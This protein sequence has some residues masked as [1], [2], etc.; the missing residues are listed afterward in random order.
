MTSDLK[1]MEMKIYRRPERQSWP[2]LAGRQKTAVPE[3]V[4]STVSRIL[5]DVRKGGDSK[6]REYVRALDGYDAGKGDLSVT[7]REMEEATAIVSE[8]LKSAIR[9]AAANIRAFHAAQHCRDIELE[10][11]PGVV[12]R[13]KNVPVGNVGLYIPGGTAPLFSTVLMLAVPAS[14]AGCGRTA[15]FTPP[16]PDGKVSPAILYCASLCGVSEVYRIGGAV[17]VAVMAYGTETIRKVDKIF[18]PGN[19]YVTEAKRQVS[20]DCA[21]DMPAGPSEVM[22]LAD[23]S[24]RAEYVA[25]DFLS[26]LEHGRDSQAILVSTS[27]QLVQEVSEALAGQL[28]SLSRKEII[29]ASIRRSMA[30]IFDTEEEMVEFSNFYAPEH[31]IIATCDY[32]KT[33]EGIVNAGSVFLG[34]WS[35]ES[36]G[37]YASGTNHT[38]PTGGWAVSCSGVSL[39]SFMKKITF[40]EISA[41]GLLSLGPVI[42]RM[43]LAEGLD[44]HAASVRIRLEDIREAENGGTAYGTGENRP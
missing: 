37:D 20:Q 25:A 24:A 33:A 5:E 27:E 44:A 2:V 6:V 9:T 23:E 26:Q 38:L 21:I 4:R 30:V 11:V 3:Q 12:C 28:S 36:A 18:G 7:A 31:L 34:N 40:Q 19:M 8:S 15:L 42:E 16:G 32:R 10:T 17:A 41:S 29:G 14:L 13:Q 39:A 22:I 1:S 43:A 35:T